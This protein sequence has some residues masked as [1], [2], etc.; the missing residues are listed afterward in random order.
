MDADTLL[1]PAGGR[2]TATVG[3]RISA[4][5]KPYKNVSPGNLTM[6]QQAERICRNEATTKERN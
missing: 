2:A 5:R 1:S 3:G 6:A 4:R